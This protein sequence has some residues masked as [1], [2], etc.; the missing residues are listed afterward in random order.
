MNSF[1]SLA[2]SIGSIVAVAYHTW[3]F[4]FF[5]ADTDQTALSFDS[6]PWLPEGSSVSKS[7]VGLI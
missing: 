3:V 4:Y 1:L 6:W 5:G 7:S 2:F